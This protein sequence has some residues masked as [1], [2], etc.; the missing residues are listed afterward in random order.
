M[1]VI[2]HQLRKS[3]ISGKGVFAKRDINKGDLI[4]K[5][6]LKERR[7]SKKQFSQFRKRYQKTLNKFGYW[8]NQTLIYPIDN[9]KYLNHSCDN[10]V[11]NYGDSDKA[12]RDIK[13]GEEL[14]YDYSIILSKKE[15]IKCRC[16]SKNCKETVS[17][18]K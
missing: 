10:N 14:T 1:I 6:G 18:R 13:K 15:K 9:T 16:G 5:I 12:L 8:Q 3:K 17:G 4:V 2:P 7:Y 11:G